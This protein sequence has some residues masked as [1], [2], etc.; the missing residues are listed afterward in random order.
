MGTGKIQLPAIQGW[1]A[2]Q[3]SNALGGAALANP[4]AIAVAIIA[5]LLS[6]S[7]TPYEDYFEGAQFIHFMLG[8]ATVALAAPL[9]SAR[10]TVIRRW[11]PIAAALAAGS[12]AAMTSALALASL[13][14]LPVEF[15]ASLAPKSTTAPVA[16][17]VA[18]RLG[19]SPTL[20]ATLVILTG[21]TGAV[22]APALLTLMRVRDE[23]ARGLALGVACHG[24]G[25]ARAFRESE[26][27]GAF[28]G[29]GLGANAV[30]TAL[31]APIILAFFL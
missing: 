6:V 28:A 19:G 5:V 4:V 21:V 18:E 8:P 23:A 15:F 11:A 9:Y 20:T 12:L 13:V 26:T 10:R 1:G 3:I 25:A 22:I 29:I 16:I 30:L 27:T 7:G 2:E 14:G 24:I 31:L 17:G